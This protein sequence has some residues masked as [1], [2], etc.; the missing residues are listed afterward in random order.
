LDIF[1]DHYLSTYDTGNNIIF[2]YTN[3]A[4]NE[5]N[6]RIRQHITDNVYIFNDYFKTKEEEKFYSSCRI[7]IIEK[8]ENQ[9]LCENFKMENI[10]NDIITCMKKKYY[11]ELVIQELNNSY[12]YN[13]I[14]SKIESIVDKIN[15]IKNDYK[16]NKITKC[17]KISHDGKFIPTTSVLYQIHEH[18]IHLFNKNMKEIEELILEFVNIKDEKS[19]KITKYYEMICKI[20]ARS[21]WNEFDRTVRDIFI[22]I[23][24]SNSITTN[25]SQGS[26]YSNVYIDMRNIFKYDKNIEAKKRFYTAITRASDSVHILI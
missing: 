10:Q 2:T 18:N 3:Y 12:V 11:N 22:N 16:V 25:K 15:L 9:Y 24:Y 21:I 5:Y 17:D 7:N 19:L 8:E 13:Y 1:I 20:L 6:K 23:D 4:K 14:I 26:T